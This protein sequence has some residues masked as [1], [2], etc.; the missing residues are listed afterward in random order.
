MRSPL[1]WMGVSATL[2]SG[3][4]T[5]SIQRGGDRRTVIYRCHLNWS[6]LKQKP[7]YC[8]QRFPRRVTRHVS[9]IT[10]E[11][12][13][14]HLT[15]AEPTFMWR[16]TGVVTAGSTLRQPQVSGPCL[17]KCQVMKHVSQKLHQTYISQVDTSKEVNHLDK[18]YW[19]FWL[20]VGPL[21]K[22]V[23]QH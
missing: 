10:D 5:L 23:V 7:V 19:Q 6:R 18:I 2:Q 9:S 17:Q 3:R 4:Y 15:G 21:S 16:L 1:N 8:H 14:L 20:N 12:G 13:H 22:T 11:A